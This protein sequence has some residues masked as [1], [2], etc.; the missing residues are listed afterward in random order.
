MDSDVPN[1]AYNPTQGQIAMG[2][3]FFGVNGKPLA[4]AS[5]LDPQTPATA[6]QEP[7][8]SRQTLF[9][10]PPLVRHSSS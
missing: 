6:L 10:L 1:P 2:F 4:E 7:T 3:I 9:G 8:A 5:H